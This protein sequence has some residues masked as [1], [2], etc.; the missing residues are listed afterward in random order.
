MIYHIFYYITVYLKNIWEIKKGARIKN[1]T[2]FNT[3]GLKK[4]T[5]NA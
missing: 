5:K 1:P 2:A 3:A 4:L